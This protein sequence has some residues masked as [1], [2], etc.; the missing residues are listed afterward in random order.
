MRDEELNS[1]IVNVL[2]EIFPKQKKGA[3]R[4]VNDELNGPYFAAKKRVMNESYIKWYN[5]MG[6]K[7]VIENLFRMISGKIKDIIINPRN[8]PEKTVNCLGL[9]DSVRADI[10][11][12]TTIRSAFEVEKKRKEKNSEKQVIPN[13]PA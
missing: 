4:D 10:R 2:D 1:E 6:G 3:S 11:F 8:T 13:S 7:D 12:I 5:E 9:I